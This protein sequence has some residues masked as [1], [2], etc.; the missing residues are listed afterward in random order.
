MPNLNAT[1]ADSFTFNVNDGTVDS[2]PATVTV[3]ITSAA[4]TPAFATPIPTANG[5]TVQIS[6]YDSSYSWAGTATALGSVTI[7]GT[8]LVTVTGV[9]AG[10]SSTATITTTKSNTVGGTADVT[11][12]SLLAALNPIFGTQTPTAD[13]FTVLISNYDSNYT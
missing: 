11:E 13:G 8:G 2:S 1:G 9:A 7:D 6:N 10:T 3:S 12:T 4:L 5:F